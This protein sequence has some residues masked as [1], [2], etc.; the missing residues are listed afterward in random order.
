MSA[1]QPSGRNESGDPVGLGMLAMACK[2]QLKTCPYKCLE[3]KNGGVVQ[4][5]VYACV[6]VCIHLHMVL[7]MHVF[8]DCI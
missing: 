3:Q 4:T 1:G 8:V 7:C 6:G 2:F 5:H